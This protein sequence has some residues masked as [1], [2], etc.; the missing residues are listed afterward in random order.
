MTACPSCGTPVSAEDARF[1]EACGHELAAPAPAQP[2]KIDGVEAGRWLSSAGPP[3]ACANCGGTTF[4]D[5]YC[6]DCGQR[7]SA[8]LDHRELDLG[9][10]A[11]VTDRGLR[12]HRNEDAMGLATGPG[13]VL[14]LVCDGVSSSTRPDMASHA[15]VEAATPVMLTGMI[16]GADPPAAITAAARAAQAAATLAAGGD[17]G[18]NPPACTFVCAVVTADAVTVGWVGDSRAYWLPDQGEPACLT[19]DD[20]LAG[21]LA[22]SGVDVAQIPQ[23]GAATAL[24]RWLGADA[25]DTDPRLA[26]F[27]P[28]G[29]GRVLVCSDGVFRYRPIAADLAAVAPAKSPLD[30]ARDLV[31]FAVEQGGHDNITAILL[32]YPP[33]AGV[34]W[35]HEGS[36]PTVKHSAFEERS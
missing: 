24:M 28:A 3:S 19:Q 35:V 12:H 16:E 13:V 20:S 26:T 10:V 11:G 8:G 6:Q 27:T 9:L 22:A 17:P 36:E 2:A 29:P 7:R 21:Q 31:T 30:T 25:T 15:A 23:G 1:C 34:G 5:D 4:D 33:E 14:G 32:P 18:P